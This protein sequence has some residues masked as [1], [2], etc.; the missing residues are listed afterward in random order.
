MPG[1]G[2][3]DPTADSS[4]TEAPVLAS[5]ASVSSLYG[6]WQQGEAYGCCGRS[7]VLSKSQ[8]SP[9]LRR[10]RCVKTTWKADRELRKEASAG[11]PRRPTAPC[12]FRLRVLLPGSDNRGPRGGRGQ[13]GPEHR[14]RPGTG[15]LQRGSEG[16][17]LHGH[18]SGCQLAAWLPASCCHGGLGGTG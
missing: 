7:W 18:G 8:Q 9:K 3:Q 10:P 1:H 16:A 11:R 2:A 5:C 12:A 13:G 15:S 17:A 4:V 6:G 14:L